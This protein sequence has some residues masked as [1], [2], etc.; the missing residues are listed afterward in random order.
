[1]P[2]FLDKRIVEQTH[3]TCNLC[4][5]SN[6]RRLEAVLLPAPGVDAPIQADLLP[7]GLLIF[8]QLIRS[9]QAGARRGAR[10]HLGLAAVWGVA[11]LLYAPN[12]PWLAALWKDKRERSRGAFIF[13]LSTRVRSGKSI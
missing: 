9:V 5:L 8:L 2:G 10:H 3:I 4:T 12:P 1:M 7:L 6:G 13:T 11:G